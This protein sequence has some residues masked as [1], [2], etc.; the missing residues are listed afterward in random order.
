[1]KSIKTGPGSIDK[2]PIS[3]NT[4]NYISNQ[5]QKESKHFYDLQRPSNFLQMEQDWS[6]VERK[7]F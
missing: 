2:E 6:F 1:M 5:C 4:N 3:Y 7:D